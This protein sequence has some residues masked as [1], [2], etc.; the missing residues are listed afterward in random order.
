VRRAWVK[1]RRKSSEPL[2]ETRLLGF[3]IHETLDNYEL[4]GFLPQRVSPVHSLLI[5]PHEHILHSSIGVR[6]NQSIIN[7]HFTGVYLIS[8]YFI[9][10]H[11]I[12]V[13]LMNVYF[14]DVYFMTCIF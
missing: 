3:R 4:T 5:P 8:V 10:V 9:G 11:L 12:N 1:L 6:D 14:I 2:A 7:V 13:Y